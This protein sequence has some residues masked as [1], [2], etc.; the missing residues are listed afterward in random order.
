MEHFPAEIWGEIYAFACV[1]DGWTGRALSLVSRIIHETS[2]PYKL[3]S[4]AVIGQMQLSRFAYLIEQTP[5]QLRRV[6]CIFL[7]ARTPNDAP[8]LKYMCKQDVYWVA[9]KRVLRAISPW[10]RIIHTHFVFVSPFV[11]L[12]VSLPVLEELVVHGPLDASTTT[13]KSSIQ[14]PALKHLSISCDPNILDNVLRRTPSL[15][16]LRIS[17]SALH[18]KWWATTAEYSFPTHLQRIL[19]QTPT[20][21]VVFF[22]DSHNRTMLSLR[23]LADADDRIALLKRDL[24]SETSISVQEAEAIWELSA[25]GIPWW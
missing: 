1:D 7:S 11:P 20:Q 8:G 16:N 17:A 9:L 12:P 22:K 25:D 15:V 18:S 13:D 24:S 19:I 23:V 10:V 2:K 4:I 3:Q 14:F 6:R 21:T 5:T